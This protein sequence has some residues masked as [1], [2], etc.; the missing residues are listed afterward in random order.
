MSIIEKPN[1]HKFPEEY[2]NEIFMLWYNNQKPTAN[3]L[4]MLIPPEK[5]SDAVPTEGTVA[6]WINTIFKPRA[7]LLDE[8]V[9]AELEGRMVKEKIEMMERHADV[10]M[11]MQDIAIEYLSDPEIQ[12]KLT[13][14]TTIRLLIEG[15]Q[16]ERESRGLPQAMNKMINKSDEELLKELENIIDQSPARI[17]KIDD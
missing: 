14:S 12:T 6:S 16:I 17:E 5:F 11:K 10:A 7:K 4:F 8:Q 3:N 2:K 13:P 1:I 9:M 15:I